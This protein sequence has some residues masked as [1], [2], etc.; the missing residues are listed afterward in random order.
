MGAKPLVRKR[1]QGNALRVHGAP[2]ARAGRDNP[3]LKNQPLCCLA[4]IPCGASD[5]QPH[6]VLVCAT[7]ALDS[8]SSR[9]RHGSDLVDHNGDKRRVWNG[10]PV[11]GQ[12][13]KMAPG[14]I[15]QRRSLGAH[16]SSRGS[17]LGV[18]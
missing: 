14:I 4:L 3:L 1:A 7:L 2:L 5:A 13:G 12:D 9:V 16:E 6:T 10:I 17:L 15:G 11:Y 18:Y 8:R